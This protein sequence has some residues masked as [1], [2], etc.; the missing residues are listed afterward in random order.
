MSLGGRL[1]SASGQ[2]EEASLL[3]DQG[4]VDI[5]DR[6]GLAVWEEFALPSV[7]VCWQGGRSLIFSFAPP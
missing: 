4:T 5:G 2:Q 7:A 1:P 3:D 6:Y